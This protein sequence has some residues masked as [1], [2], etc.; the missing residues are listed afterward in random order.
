MKSVLDF[1]KVS[2]VISLKAFQG[3]KTSNEALDNIKGVTG[4][5]LTDELVS[6]LEAN[7]PVNKKKTSKKFSLAV[8]DAKFSK[9]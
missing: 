5:E 3:F 1:K 2:Q 8:L 6:F 7:L 4:R 9:T